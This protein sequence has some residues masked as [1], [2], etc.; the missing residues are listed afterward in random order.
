MP[1]AHY[2][3]KL[4]PYGEGSKAYL[5]KQPNKKVMIFVHGFRGHAMNT[6][7]D[8]PSLLLAERDARCQGCDF[9]FYGYD[10]FY[11]PAANSAT[12]LRQFLGVLLSR[13]TAIVNPILV[14]TARRD[15]GFMYSDALIVAHSLGAVVARR[16][17]L[18]AHLA[19][20]AWVKLVRLAFFAPAHMGANV[21]KLISEVF[22]SIPYVGNLIAP[23]I[24]FKAAV[25]HDLEA[26]CQT[27]QVLLQDMQ[28]AT[29][30]GP[31]PHLSAKVWSA[32][33]ENIVQVVRFPTDPVPTADSVIRRRRHV[34]ICK[35]TSRD[36]QAVREVLKLL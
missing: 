1:A 2:L 3:P 21:I 11:T 12:D 14:R 10:G 29:K 36:A 31:V 18:D 15:L 24:R 16:A 22:T 8:F 26:G 25:L 30:Q 33:W 5:A 20:E 35:P 28:A 6:W 13:P 9:I 27:L 32:E 4:L 17:V 19:G 7:T 34:N 23:A